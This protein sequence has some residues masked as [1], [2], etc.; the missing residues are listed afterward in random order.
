[1][2]GEGG[3]VFREVFVSFVF[4]AEHQVAQ[5]VVDFHAPLFANV[6]NEAFFEP[7]RQI[8]CH[9]ILHNFLQIRAEKHRI[10]V[11]RGNT[12]AH[13]AAQILVIAVKINEHFIARYFR[14]SAR[15]HKS[16]FAAD[17]ALLE[18][19][20]VGIDDNFD[21]IVHPVLQN[22]LY[23]V[24]V[25]FRALHHKLPDVATFAVPIG[26]KILTLVLRAFVIVLVKLHPIFTELY[27]R[28]L[29][30]DGEGGEGA[31]QDEDMTH[32]VRL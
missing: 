12:F 7:N 2:T 16:F 20:E 14:L 9:G 32:I 29:G 27:L 19:G 1:M 10:H 8:E 30:G 15:I 21:F 17:V 31:E 26:D 25:V 23:L 22:I 24:V 28:G 6:R 4:A 13:L 11:N 3:I 18:V 5:L